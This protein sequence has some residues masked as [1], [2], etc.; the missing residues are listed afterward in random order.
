MSSRIWLRALIFLL[1]LCFGFGL[2]SVVLQDGG[3]SPAPSLTA[4]AWH[5]PTPAGTTEPAAPGTAILIL[6]VDDLGGDQPRLLAVWMAAHDAAQDQLILY[7]IPISAAA[8]GSDERPLAALFGWSSAEGL[9]PGFERSLAALV[10][11][12]HQATVVMDEAAFGT[13][14][15]VLGGA[16]LGGTRLRGEE[17]LAFLRLLQTKPEALLAAQAELLLALRP[18]LQDL[19]PTPDISQLERLYPE[20]VQLSL[21]VQQLAALVA[22]MLPFEAASIRVGTLLDQPAP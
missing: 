9:D 15:N 3:G 16:D 20:H 17:V 11:L 5:R 10:P 1:F 22:P 8:P 14:V 13:A 4:T 12:P 7:G 2:L 19:G 18:G 6:G 21:D